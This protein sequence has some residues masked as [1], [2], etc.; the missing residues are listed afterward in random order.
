MLLIRVA[1]NDAHIGEIIAL[2]QPF[3]QRVLVGRDVLDADRNNPVPNALAQ[4]AGN[5]RSGQFDLF[6][7]FLLGKVL[8]VIHVR[9]HDL[10][11]NML[12]ILRAQAIFPLFA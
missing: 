2:P 12:H 11:V 9:N 10:Q 8:V 4:D 5:S 7:D 6:R 1:G 3:R